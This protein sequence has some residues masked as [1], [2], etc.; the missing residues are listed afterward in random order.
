M[1]SAL[2]Q[3]GD[4]GLTFGDV[5]KVLAVREPSSLNLERGRRARGSFF[6]GGDVGAGL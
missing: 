5:G 6:T 1:V 2:R 4:P 3:E